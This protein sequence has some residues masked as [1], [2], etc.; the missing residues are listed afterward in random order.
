MATKTISSV[1][2]KEG[3]L[4]KGSMTKSKTALV[5]LLTFSL[6]FLSS[7]VMAKER[8]GAELKVFKTDG[9]TIT[10]ELIA[11]KQDSLLMV[12]SISSVDVSINLND[13]ESIEIVR[14]PKILMGAGLGLAIG[15]SVGV[16]TGFIF[17][18]DE[19]EA[20]GENGE[21]KTRSA[22][23]KAL[24]IGIIFGLIGSIGGGI[25][26]AYSGGEDIIQIEGLSEQDISLELERLRLKARF[27]DYK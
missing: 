12:D 19:P 10:G 6:T 24:T 4:R 9:Q 20:N 22:S 2:E 16:L 5:I 26:G 14:K 27:P 17:G 18:G 25:T 8:R 1:L 23:Q 7:H 11:V 15:A 13:I 3:Q 21:Y